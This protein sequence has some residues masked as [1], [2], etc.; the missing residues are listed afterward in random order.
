MGGVAGLVSRE[1]QDDPL[2]LTLFKPGV[3]AS[4]RC[5]HNFVVIER[6]GDALP[7]E[8]SLASFLD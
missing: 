5:Y 6:G 8:F 3:A 7:A 2:D 1:F 4:V